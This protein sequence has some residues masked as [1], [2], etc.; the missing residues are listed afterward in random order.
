M[1]AIGVLVF[2][3]GVFFL[4]LAYTMA[5]HGLYV[6]CF[7]GGGEGARCALRFYGEP[8]LSSALYGTFLGIAAAI[9]H[10][11]G[12]RNLRWLRGPAAAGVPWSA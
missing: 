7:A 4:A 3:T 8:T 10:H 9:T 6:D 12:V 2:F 11:V 1:K 5:L